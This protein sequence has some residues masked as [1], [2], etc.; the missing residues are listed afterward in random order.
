MKKYFVIFI[1]SNLFFSYHSYSKESNNS[2]RDSIDN[3]MLENS[4]AKEPGL[5]YFDLVRS[6]DYSELF[7]LYGVSRKKCVKLDH[8]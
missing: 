6:I 1:F 3:F 4:I 2:L 7:Y 5:V 8:Y